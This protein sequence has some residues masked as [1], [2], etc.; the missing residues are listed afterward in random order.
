[1]HFLLKICIICKSVQRTHNNNIGFC[2]NV[3]APFG[4]V[5]LMRMFDV[6]ANRIE[7][8]QRMNEKTTAKPTTTREKKIMTIKEIKYRL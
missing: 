7:T 2:V 4:Q 1:M 6:C 5:R 8:I 3:S